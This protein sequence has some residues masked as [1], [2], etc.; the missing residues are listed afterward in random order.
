M[1][2]KEWT[3][4]RVAAYV[5]IIGGTLAILGTLAV[6]VDDWIV[7]DSELKSSERRIIQKIEHE[8]VKTRT[9]YITELIERKTLLEEELE[10]ATSPG[11]IKALTRKIDTLNERIKKLRGE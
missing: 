8:A 5:S 11:K 7:T 2:E 6:Y 4:G 9:V 3:H 10:D 1:A